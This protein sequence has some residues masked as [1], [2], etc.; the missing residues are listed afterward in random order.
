[1]ASAIAHRSQGRIVTFDIGEDSR[2]AELWSALP[3]NIRCCIE[4]RTMD[5]VQ[6]MRGAIARGER[7]QAALLDSLHTAEQVWAEFQL[8]AQLVCPGGLILVHD[9]CYA[10]GT[11]EQA[12]QQIEAA[13][14]GVTRLWTAEAGVP[15]DDHLGLAVIENRRHPRR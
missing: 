10:P 14:Y 4:L 3:E 11:V 12:L 1:M 2:R 8:A 7:Y 5:S 6:G 15:E 9:V 13:G